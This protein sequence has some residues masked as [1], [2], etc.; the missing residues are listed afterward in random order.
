MLWYE[1]KGFDFEFDTETK[2]F[3]MECLNRTGPELHPGV[4]RPHPLSRRDRTVPR[5]LR[6]MGLPN[7]VGFGLDR[8]TIVR[9]ELDP[10]FRTIG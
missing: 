3:A 1:F 4:G 6:V 7:P 10:G 9:I 2:S 5:A 8:E